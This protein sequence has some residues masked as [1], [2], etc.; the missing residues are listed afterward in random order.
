MKP[1]ARIAAVPAL[2][3]CLLALGAC[4]DKSGV[5]AEN[6]SVGSVAGKVAASEIKPKPGRWES[7]VKIEEMEIANVPPE[8]REAMKQQAGVSQTVSTCLTPEQVESLDGS[9]FKDQAPGC[10]YERFSMTGGKIDAVMVCGEGPALEKTTLMGDYGEESYA[11]RMT[12]EGEAQPGMRA[13]T[14]MSMTS[15]RVGECTG[16]EKP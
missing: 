6:E 7:V 3:L 14:V 16:E 10:K 1:S 9:M 13:K 4:G 2:A 12:S 15:R 11:I 5:E 8:V